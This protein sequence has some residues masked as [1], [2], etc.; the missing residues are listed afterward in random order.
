MNKATEDARQKARD[1][2]A[3]A[4]L[5]TSPAWKNTA[6]LIRSGWENNFIR[7]AI[8][9]LQAFVLLSP[10]VPEEETD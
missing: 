2:Y 9:A 1:L 3:D 5:A 10:D 8:D 4:L 7:P 6:N